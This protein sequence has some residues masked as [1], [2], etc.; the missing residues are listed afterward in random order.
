MRRDAGVCDIPLELRVDRRVGERLAGHLLPRGRG[1]PC[2]PEA[3][4]P[5]HAHQGGWRPNPRTAGVGE[6]PEGLGASVTRPVGEEASGWPAQ[7][8]WDCGC[9]RDPRGDST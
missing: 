3:G 1:R 4:T 7:P 2:A 5:P 8:P 9:V 6:G